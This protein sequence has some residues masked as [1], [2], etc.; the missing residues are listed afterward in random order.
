MYTV[1]FFVD[2][3]RTIVDG[4]KFTAGRISNCIP[5]QAIVNLQSIDKFENRIAYLCV[6]SVEAKFSF[7]PQ[8]RAKAF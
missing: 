5:H 3:M 7:R 6:K 4:V 8:L 1:T 2:S